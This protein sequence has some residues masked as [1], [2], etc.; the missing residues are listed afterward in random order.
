LLYISTNDFL[1][2]SFMDWHMVYYSPYA[3]THK[4]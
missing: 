3:K 2:F 1:F 4:P